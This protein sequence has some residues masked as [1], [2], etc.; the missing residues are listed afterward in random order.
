MFIRISLK[1][2]HLH[3]V[4]TKK[5]PFLTLLGFLHHEFTKRCHN[6]A[7]INNQ[8]NTIKECRYCSSSVDIAVLGI[9]LVYEKVKS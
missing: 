1:E 3:E 6:L 4:I 5:R 2:C 9:L 8:S 7:F